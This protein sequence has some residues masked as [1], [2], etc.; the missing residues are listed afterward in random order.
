M[1]GLSA[2]TLLLAGA[3]LAGPLPSA[4]QA[5]GPVTVRTNG[6]VTILAD[7]IEEVASDNLLVATGNVEVS[8]GTARLLADRV[9]LN[10]DTGDVVAQGRV[11]FYDG[12]DQLTGERIEYNVRTGTGVIYRGRIL[13]APAYRI[14]GE[15]LE[16]VG[17]SVY[18][19]RRGIF[20]TCE[21]DGSPAWSFRFGSATAD[22]EDLIYG[23]NASFW[24]KGVPL[25]PFFPF[26]AAA[27]RRERQTGLLPPV[28]GTSGRR[29]FFAE[30][31]FFWAISDSQDATL[32]LDFFERRGVGGSAEYRY[33]LSEGQR[34][35][36]G[37]FWVHESMQHGDDRGWG[38]LSHDWQIAPG[39]QFRADLNGVSDDGVLRLYEDSLQR[40]AAQRAES[41]VSLT[42]TLQDWNV[43]GR[44]FVYQDLTTPD[45]VELQRLP[46]LSVQ[47]VRQPF[48]G[49][50]GLLYQV[51]ASAVH[52]YRELGSDRTRA[53]LRPRLSRPI[54]LAGYATVG[55][56]ALLHSIEPRVHYIR[57]VG[58]NFYSLPIWDEHV[59]RVPEGNWLEYSVTN[60]L[61]G[62]TVSP[63][64]TEPERLELTRFTLAHA[65]DLEGRRW[66]N[67][68]GDLTVQATKVLRLRGDVSYNV[69]HGTFVAGTTD[70]AVTL[71]VVTATVGT[72]F[73]RRVP[74]VPDW[75]EI[76]GTYNPGLAVLDRPNVNFLEGSLSVEVSKNLVLRVR[77]N[78]DA[79]TDTFV[80]SRFGADFKLQCWALL[81]EYVN[82][83]PEFAGKTADNEFRFSLNLLGVGGVLSTR[84]G[85]SDSGARL[86]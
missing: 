3:L 44:V 43:V 18:H 25:I 57:V 38:R 36:L 24:A 34:G 64:G 21:D 17:E 86:K 65:Y 14:A 50:P 8:R 46:E 7:R 56:D 62:R 28:F 53:D 71:P 49:L 76:P 54:P 55:L 32:G 23:T 27:I 2:A 52:F 48:P 41:N 42:R 81:V 69:E 59:D 5:P 30:M 40:R 85:A 47:G 78:Y 74:F 45:P 9:E 70:M 22:L 82:R 19:V 61:R 79:R 4:A 6:D 33:I 26:F 63:E 29:G 83:S 16:R 73:D 12:D 60:R 15:R 68:A 31:P 13:V 72:R 39:F 20:T 58:K 80:E 67:L 37:G 77:T 35:T 51:D 84:L 66:G 11:I 10:R 1:R 75:V